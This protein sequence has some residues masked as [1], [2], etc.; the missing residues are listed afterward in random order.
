[1]WASFVFALSVVA[2]AAGQN[3]AAQPPPDSPPLVRFIEIVFP[4]QGNTSLIEP[5][6]YLYYIHTRPSRPSVG[7]WIAY[8]RGTVL[9]DFRRLWSLGFL[10]D[11]TIE[12]NDVPY[13]NGVVGKHVI[14]KLEER[15][16]VKIVH[17]AGS[18][19][20]TRDQIEDRLKEAKLSVR[21]DTFIDVALLRKVETTLR[22]LLKEKGFQYA[23]VTH[24][25][26]PL[27][28]AP[29]LAHLT[30]KLD[31]GP[32]LRLRDVTFD[33]NDRI[34]D[35]RLRAQMKT[36]S[37]GRWW[38]PG[39]LEGAKAY[40]EA[41]FDED[42][43]RLMQYYRDR[44]FVEAQIGTPQLTALERSHDGTT[45][46]VG[47]TVPV[48]EG[49]RYKV[50]DVTFD[51]GAVINPEALKPLFKLTDDDFYSEARV[52]KGLE[53]ARDVYGA[54]GYFEFTGYPDLK[55]REGSSP[56]I[57]DVTMRLLE[58][59]QYFINRIA[60]KGNSVTRDPVIRRELLLAEGAVFN[61]EA[62]KNSIRRV[63]QLGYFKPIEERTGLTVEKTPGTDNKV[64]VTVKVE[65]Q[66][67]NVINFGAGLSQ[68]EGLFGNVAY[69]TSNLLGRGETFTLSLQQGSRANVYQVGVAEPYLF[70]RSI[71]GSIDL[72][73][74][75]YNYLTSANVVGYSEV[76]EGA[77]MAIGRPITRFSRGFLNYT[78]ETVNVAISDSLKNS[79]TTGRAG[80]P[81]FN[82]YAD[83]GIHAD[84]RISPTFVFNTVDHPIFPHRGVR[85]TASAPLA[86]T[87]LGGSFNYFKPDLEMV[88]FIPTSRR[89]GVGLRA[90]GGWLRTYGRT[91][92]VPYYLR[93]FLGGETQIRGV[94][95][96]TVG[97]VNS[98]N[99]AIGGNKFALFNAEYYIDVA[100]PVRLLLF[101]DAGQA[102]SET[103]RV[104]LR[105]LRTS[106]GAEA[107][108][109]LPV[110]NVPFRLIWSWNR[111]R[112]SFQPEFAFK[113]AIGTTF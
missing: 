100:G 52:R 7:E 37:A 42:A 49:S 47:L 68:Y 103:E 39:F 75:K 61:T 30:F 80:S 65:E 13:E 48:T 17:Y 89:T 5:E 22:D 66:N 83:Q 44:G 31:E 105:T 50:G 82:P 113:F 95:I 35:R 94:D 84:S 107:R 8:D 76:R 12:V 40:Q 1:M 73:S 72:Y 111:Y 43:D 26:E 62:L 58:G 51:G 18:K 45:Q 79:T 74:R 90:Q 91:R 19:A 101:H 67:R 104:N 36:N 92:E 60:F 6:T 46:W 112:D 77:S 86:A 59:K 2:G 97:P 10:D 53:K 56:P 109:F 98:D 11:L 108:I 70:D 93:Y 9:E 78:Y 25:I 71:S 55:P 38:L 33:G 15:Q 69:S 57:V 88:W 16:R 99:I 24:A 64:D 54:L 81:L 85:V 110:L 41:K 27:A 28:G 32:K 34:G 23:S 3:T 20:V 4:E 102:F 14:Y 21:L 87:G 63:N 96:R 106:S 29:K